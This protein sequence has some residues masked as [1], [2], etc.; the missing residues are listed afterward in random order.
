[1]FLTN[2]SKRFLRKLYS[3]AKNYKLLNCA[4]LAFISNLWQIKRSALTWSLRPEWLRFSWSALSAS[5]DQRS[6]S[7]SYF[8]LR[9]TRAVW[10]SRCSY[11]ISVSRHSC[12]K[13]K[14]SDNRN[15][16]IVLMVV[17]VLTAL[18]QLFRCI[19]Y[20]LKAHHVTTAAPSIYAWNTKVLN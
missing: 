15:N 20:E 17:I 12:N 2:H 10:S 19:K 3:G 13:S 7:C 11:S 16:T 5:S 6:S 9:T 1:M 14:L 18:R 4:G 8:I